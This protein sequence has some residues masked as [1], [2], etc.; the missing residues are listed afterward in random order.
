MYATSKN[1]AL[2]ISS[3]VT[4][5]TYRLLYCIAI[6]DWLKLVFFPPARSLYAGECGD[7]AGISDAESAAR[8]E[9]LSA[10]GRL[11]SSWLSLCAKVSGSLSTQCRRRAG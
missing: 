1:N 4:Q 11:G 8:G 10:L 5:H 6:S 3:F 7:A 2:F 9:S